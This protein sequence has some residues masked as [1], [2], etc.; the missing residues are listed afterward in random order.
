MALTM[1]WRVNHYSAD[2]WQCRC[3]VYEVIIHR[4]WN[5]RTK[6]SCQ[7]TDHTNDDRM[8]LSPFWKKVFPAFEM[9][10]TQV[11]SLLEEVEH[12]LP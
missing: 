12:V 2:E 7:I 3:G 9:K 6:W 10:R 8:I 11:L 1:E 5:D 4:H